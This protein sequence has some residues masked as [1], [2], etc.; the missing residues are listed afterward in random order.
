MQWIADN[1]GN[2]VIITLLVLMVIGI[3]MKLIKDKRKGKSSCGCN[4]G[5]CAMSGMCHNQ[6]G[7]K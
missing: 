4:C 6:T 5:H 2:I 7:K 3:V 1:I